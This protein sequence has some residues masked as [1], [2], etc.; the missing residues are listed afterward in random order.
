MTAPRVEAPTIEEPDYEALQDA[1]VLVG[2]DRVRL[3]L[4]RR[5]FDSPLVPLSK[6]RDA[7]PGL[8][9]SIEEWQRL[10]PGAGLLLLCENAAADLLGKRFCDIPVWWIC[11][12]ELSDED[13]MRLKHAK[14]DPLNTWVR[15]NHPDLYHCRLLAC[16]GVEDHPLDAVINASNQPSDD[17]GVLLLVYA[18]STS[19]VFAVVPMDYDTGLILQAVCIGVE[20]NYNPYRMYS[21]AE[22]EASRIEAASNPGRSSLYLPVG[23]SQ[24]NRTSA[25]G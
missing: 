24:A 23:V 2:K 14:R 11:V 17:A 3:A 7:A 13:L 21:D 19:C 10:H 8:L 15:V 22:L 1:R 12:P 18:S 5:S 16:L 20:E 4:Y 9:T 6:V 25:E